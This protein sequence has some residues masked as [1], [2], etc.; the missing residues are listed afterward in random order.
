MLTSF[1]EN[2]SGV[3]YVIPPGPD[4]FLSKIIIL[5]IFFSG[6]RIAVA[7]R[8]SLGRGLGDHH[9]GGRL[10]GGEEGGPRGR[11]QVQEKREM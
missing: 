4:P 2:S 9:R 1:F 8:R 11:R 3:S 7:R 10:E 5:I 6:F